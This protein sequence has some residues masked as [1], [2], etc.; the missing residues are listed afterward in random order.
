MRKHIRT[1]GP[2]ELICLTCGKDFLEAS[3]LK[4]HMITHTG[5]KAF[6]CEYEGCEK[7]F[8]LKF[9]LSTHEKIHRGEKPY[10]CTFDKCEKAFSQQINLRVHYG[11]HLNH[12]NRR[13]NEIVGKYE[14]DAKV[15]KSE[16]A[17]TAAPKQETK[18]CSETE[19]EMPWILQNSGNND[20]DNTSVFSGKAS[21]EVNEE[22]DADKIKCIR[23]NCRETFPTKNIMKS[24]FYEMHCKPVFKCPDCLGTFNGV[25]ELKSHI[26][27]CSCSKK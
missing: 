6:K 1:H 16:F 9:N 13:L 12:K 2:R 24:H 15:D 20:N 22:R 21:V 3:K 18:S 19:N 25:E 5:D 7:S 26:L 8:S 14:E 27:T 11:I 10:I 17:A 4:R 23:N